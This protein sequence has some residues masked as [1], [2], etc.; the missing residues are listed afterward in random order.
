MIDKTTIR[1]KVFSELLASGFQVHN[2]VPELPSGEP[3][4]VARMI[5]QRHRQLILM[6][7]ADFISRYEDL[8]INEFADGAEINLD[9]FQVSVQEV[10]SQDDEKLFKYASLTW[11]VPVTQGY[12]RRTKFLVKDLSNNKLV[13]IFALGDPVFNLGPRDN[14]IGWTKEDKIDR[15]FNVLDAFVLGAVEPY[16]QLIAGKLVALMVV[17]NEIQKII[18]DKYANKISIIQGEVKN[19]TPVLFTTTSALGK[20]SI[21]NRIKYNERLIFRPAGYT[22]GFGHFHFS[23]EL[24]DEL[25]ALVEDRD[26]FRSGKFGQGP[27]YRFRTIRQALQVL[28]LEGDMLK[29]GIQREVYLAPL[30]TE[31]VSF[32]LGETVKF[33]SFIFPQAEMSDFWVNRWAKARLVNRPEILN[34]KK[35]TI[36]LS[37]ETENFVKQMR[38][39]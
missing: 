26:D 32:L 22:K 2:G 27:N 13:G 35:N 21:Y 38:L 17:S 18:K 31:W 12:G 37:V 20:S 14:S 11:A 29:H 28:G 9:K 30:G 7:N 39:F 15:L 5:H 6:Q 8:L 16:R 1:R 36:R 3:K 4:E 25:K 33:E 19:S 23:D 34:Y 24:F 10:K